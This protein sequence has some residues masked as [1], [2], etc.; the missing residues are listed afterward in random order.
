[1]ASLS[2]E[3]CW[4]CNKKTRHMNGNCSGCASAKSSLDRKAHFDR[5]DKLTIEQRVRLLEEAAYQNSLE[6]DHEVSD[7]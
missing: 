4:K 3:F 1:M 7:G 2:T 6:G 5:L